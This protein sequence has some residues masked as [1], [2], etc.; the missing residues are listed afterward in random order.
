[1]KRA[2]CD[3]LY[4]LVTAMLHDPGCAVSLPLSPSLPSRGAGPPK[5]L[6][7]LQT[8]LTWGYVPLD[9]IV[10]AS[11]MQSMGIY[12]YLKAWVATLLS[13]SLSLASLSLIGASLPS[14]S[15]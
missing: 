6:R 1:M 8:S 3:E 11:T 4:R 13:I 10:E 14:V 12:T 7:G 2:R 9:Y 15:H 5:T